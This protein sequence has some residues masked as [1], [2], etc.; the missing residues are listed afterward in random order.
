M[1]H[2]SLLDADTLATILS[3]LASRPTALVRAEAVCRTWRSVAQ[4]SSMENVWRTI[5]LKTSPVAV[6]ANPDVPWSEYVCTAFTDPTHNSPL[7]TSTESKFG[8]KTRRSIS[9]QRAH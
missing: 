6:I 7:A 1:D 9:I 8:L 4:S 3:K 2:T 5:C